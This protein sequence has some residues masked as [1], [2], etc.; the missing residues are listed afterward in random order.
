MMSGE[1]VGL[2]GELLLECGGCEWHVTAL[3]R[4]TWHDSFD[5][6][7][8]ITG[9]YCPDCA[10]MARA[11]DALPNMSMHHVSQCECGC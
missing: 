9:D 4:L 6:G 3:E 7:E 5:S 1:I 8:D 2:N 11:G 10:D